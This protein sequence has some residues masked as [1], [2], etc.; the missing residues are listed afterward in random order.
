MTDLTSSELQT[1]QEGLRAQ[2]KTPARIKCD[3]LLKDHGYRRD[4]DFTDLTEKNALAIAD[5]LAAGAGR[6]EQKRCAELLRGYGFS[7]PS[8]IA[9]PVLRK[10]KPGPKALGKNLSRNVIQYHIV[11]IRHLM[12][13]EPPATA[14]EVLTR[15]LHALEKFHQYCEKGIFLS[16]GDVLQLIQDVP[17]LPDTVGQR[18][19]APLDPDSLYYPHDLAPF[20]PHDLPLFDGATR[21]DVTK[22]ANEESF[23][24]C[25][26]AGEKTNFVSFF[27]KSGNPGSKTHG[28]VVAEGQQ[29][30]ALN[31][32][33]RLPVGTTPRPAMIKAAFAELMR[34]SKIIDGGIYLPN[35][36]VESLSFVYGAMDAAMYVAYPSMMPAGLSGK[37]LGDANDRQFERSVDV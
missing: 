26:Q 8:S 34:I 20:D 23:L 30:K 13:I 15:V 9:N 16:S 14:S 32:V 35:A 11:M 25:L 19:V 3:R 17:D 7:K 2:P 31:K 28:K 36:W 10:S 29:Y 12:Q 4:I 24:R 6:E 27:A 21:D 22:F 1:I 37:I 33:L 5:G 18:R